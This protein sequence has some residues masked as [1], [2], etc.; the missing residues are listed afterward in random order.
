MALTIRLTASGYTSAP[1]AR[2]NGTP[3]RLENGNKLP[4]TVD[5]EILFGL[6]LEAIFTV[7]FDSRFTGESQEGA[8]ERMLQHS[9]LDRHYGHQEGSM[10]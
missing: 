10:M 5:C 2:G 1:T 4:S 3:L 6:T 9:I 8:A 7:R